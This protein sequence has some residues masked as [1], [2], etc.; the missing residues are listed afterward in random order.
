MSYFKLSLRSLLAVRWTFFL[1]H[2]SYSLFSLFISILS[3]AM[4]TNLSLSL[5][6]YIIYLHIYISVCPF[7][8]LSFRLSFCCSFS[9]ILYFSLSLVQMTW[10]LLTIWNSFVD[11]DRSF[12]ISSAWCMVIWCRWFDPCLIFEKNAIIYICISPSQHNILI[13]TYINLPHSLSL[14]F[15]VI[16]GRKEREGSNIFYS[17]VHGTYSRW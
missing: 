1:F 7:L 5:C 6:T 10:H 14:Y 9:V 12:S 17:I 11:L 13:Y 4:T 16:T 15:S 3:F 8:C 2:I